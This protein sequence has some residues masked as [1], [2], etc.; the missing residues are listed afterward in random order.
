MYLLR[1]AE[2]VQFEY[3]AIAADEKELK[4]LEKEA[5]E[6]GV[7]ITAVVQFDC[8]DPKSTWYH[9]FPTGRWLSVD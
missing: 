2:D 7:K 1:G 8:V 4:A 5:V 9:T 3:V 6:D